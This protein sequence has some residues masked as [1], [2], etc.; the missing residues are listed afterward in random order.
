MSLARVGSRFVPPVSPSL[1]RL[2]LSQARNRPRSVA[3]RAGS[4]ATDYSTLTALAN[5]FTA[6]LRE[7]GMQRDDV[8]GLVAER[9][10][11]TV[12]LMLAVLQGGGS[13]LPLDTTYPTARLSAMLSDARP[14]FVVGSESNR[15]R[16]PV[17]APWLSRD[18]LASMSGNLG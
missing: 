1:V 5:G 8:I 18:A 15:S 3:I 17:Q 2:I 13:C 16:L 4:K 9:E 11:A 10:P 12:A 6:A 14:R 7:A